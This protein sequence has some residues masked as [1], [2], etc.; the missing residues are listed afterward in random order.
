MAI[1]FSVL[2]FQQFL[3]NDSE[4]THEMVEEGKEHIKRERR[5]VQRMIESASRR[6]EFAN[7]FGGGDGINGGG[8][9]GAD[10]SGGRIDDDD[11]D[12]NLGG[13]A[14]ASNPRLYRQSDIVKPR[15]S[16]GPSGPQQQVTSPERSL[17]RSGNGDFGYGYVAD[18]PSKQTETVDLSPPARQT[19]GAR[20]PP[21]NI[22][23]DL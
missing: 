17:L 18:S 20:S 22:F 15:S 14:G 12:G 7:R 23:D 10:Y 6:R 4:L 1:A 2:G 8:G 21:R 19:A 16:A 3:N 11:G 5:R 13:A 9:D